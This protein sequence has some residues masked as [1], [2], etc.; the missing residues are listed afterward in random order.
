MNRESTY[1]GKLGQ[2]VRFH[3]ALAAN[4][5]EL[6]YLEGALSRFEELVNEAQEVGRHQLVRA[7][8]SLPCALRA[9]RRRRR[10]PGA[11]TDFSGL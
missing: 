5:S 4:A 3:A 2:L 8:A 7:A 10:F 6:T 9:S 11:I 1:A